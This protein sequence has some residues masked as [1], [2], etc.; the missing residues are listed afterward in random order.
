MTV[1]WKHDYIELL[2]KYINKDSNYKFL[3][4]NFTSPSPTDNFEIK[5]HKYL[6]NLKSLH[7]RNIA[8]KNFSETMFDMACIRKLKE[9][10]LG[11][12]PDLSLP[13]FSEALSKFTNLQSLSIA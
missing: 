3:S 5:F 12:T 11:F 7:L 6:K 10:S 1:N 9:L 13:Y 2:N 4:I 8:D